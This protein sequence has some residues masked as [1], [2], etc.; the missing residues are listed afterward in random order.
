[1]QRRGELPLRAARPQQGQGP[2]ARS[3]PGS[4]LGLSIVREVAAS[5]GGA[6]FAFPRD[7][8]GAVIGFTVDA[9]GS[10]DDG[11]G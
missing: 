10:E 7:G 11:R 1:H 8:G 4:G 6:P 5:H 3:R 2:H 9:G